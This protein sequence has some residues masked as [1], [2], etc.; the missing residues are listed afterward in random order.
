MLAW[1]ARLNPFKTPD[2][3][4]LA[5]LFAVVY[6]AQGMWYLPNQTV[7]IVLKDRGLTAGQVATFF[8]IT[9]I[10]WLIKPIY[11]LISDF[12]PL[13]GRRR[14]SYFV[15]TAALAAAAGGV[16]AVLGEHAYW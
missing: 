6:F 2:S 4:R 7:T 11:G 5:V 15:L 16:L 14:K 13:F 12:V 1:L 3:K 10:P 9:T 8:S